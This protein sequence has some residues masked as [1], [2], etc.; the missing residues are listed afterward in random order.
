MHSA[1]VEAFSSAQI[2]A[3]SIVK[4]SDPWAMKLL[5]SWTIT[6]IFC[7]AEGLILVSGKVLDA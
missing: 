5:V 6:P 4:A 3:I 1:V 7:E 2:F